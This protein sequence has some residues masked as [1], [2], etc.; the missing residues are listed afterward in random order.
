MKIQLKKSLRFGEKESVQEEE[1]RRTGK[2]ASG[3][4][5]LT[6]LRYGGSKLIA[7]TVL[8]ST[9]SSASQHG[10]AVLAQPDATGGNGRGIP[11]IPALFEPKRGGR[12][13]YTLVSCCQL[14]TVTLLSTCHCCKPAILYYY[15]FTTATRHTRYMKTGTTVQPH[16]ATH[17]EQHMSKERARDSQCELSIELGETP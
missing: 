10:L 1:G 7:V 5:V 12:C 16:T 13:C 4:G 2:P 17:R 9:H 6:S 11:T 3:R 14:V 8:C 15:R